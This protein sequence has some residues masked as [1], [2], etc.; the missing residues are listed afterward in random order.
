MAP[1]PEARNLESP[2]GASKTSAEVVGCPETLLSGK[3]KR[4]H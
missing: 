3:R 1:K 2:G 4:G